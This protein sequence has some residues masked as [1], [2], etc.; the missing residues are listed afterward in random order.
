M[1]SKEDVQQIK[2]VVKEIVGESVDKINTRFDKVDEKLAEHDEKF[3]AIS[4]SFDVHESKLSGMDN[5]LDSI[6]ED[7][8]HVKYTLGDIQTDAKI[9]RMRTVRL[10]QRVGL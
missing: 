8:Y 6:Q 1:L 7:V 10:E 9:D 2:E 5:R 3:E 4:H